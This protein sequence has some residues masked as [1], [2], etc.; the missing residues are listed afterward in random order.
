MKFNMKVL[1]YMWGLPLMYLGGIVL[2]KS[3]PT[4]KISGAIS[5]NG[6]HPL[7]ILGLIIMLI[8]FGLILDLLSKLIRK[9]DRFKPPVLFISLCGFMYSGMGF[10]RVFSDD[11]QPLIEYFNGKGTIYPQ[12]L[13][14]LFITNHL[15]WLTLFSIWM[16]FYIIASWNLSDSI[17]KWEKVNM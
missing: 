2:K 4:M 14:P 13:L 5:G 6:F 12:Y 9:Y 16:A 15:L 3:S 17:L 8:G 11:I 10:L 1:I 7:Q